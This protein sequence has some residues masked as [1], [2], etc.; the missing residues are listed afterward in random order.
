MSIPRLICITLRTNW[1]FHIAIK[2][3]S[4][5]GSTG[6]WREWELFQPTGFLRVWYSVQASFFWRLPSLSQKFKVCRYCLPGPAEVDIHTC[7]EVFN[8]LHI[9]ANS[10]SAKLSYL[11]RVGEAMGD[12]PAYAS[13]CENCGQ[14]EDA[15]PQHLPVQYFLKVRLRRICTYYIQVGIII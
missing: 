3:L 11:T 9:F 6:S 5:M 4:Q 14:C 10:K 8:D 12:D 2:L 1:K 7:F 15:C 13:L